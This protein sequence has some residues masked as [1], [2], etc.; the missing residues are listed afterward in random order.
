MDLALAMVTQITAYI[1]T[2]ICTYLLWCV[3]MIPTSSCSYKLIQKFFTPSITLF[4]PVYLLRITASYQM[5]INACFNRIKI[6]CL[7]IC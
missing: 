1:I 5:K 6:L 7:N 2:E 3:C 4:K